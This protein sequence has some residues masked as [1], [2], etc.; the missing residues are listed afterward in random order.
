MN[1]VSLFRNQRNAYLT[2]FALFLML[3]IWKF[4]KLHRKA[5]VV[6]CPL[7]T[8]ICLYVDVY[9]SMLLISLI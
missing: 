2:G 5:H 3:V 9:V 1:R 8:V 7:S 6:V 4:E